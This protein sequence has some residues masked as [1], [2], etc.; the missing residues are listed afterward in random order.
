MIVSFRKNNGDLLVYEENTCKLIYDIAVTGMV[1]EIT[2]IKY[3][4]I[5]NFINK[6]VINTL[7]NEKFTLIFGSISKYYPDG[8]NI[9][10]IDDCNK[11][12]LLC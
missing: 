2:L 1:R 11:S 3:P 5:I 12:A 9:C 10:T 6:I 7:T 4:H 8:V